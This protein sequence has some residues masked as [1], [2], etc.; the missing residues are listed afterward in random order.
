[1]RLV[2]YSILFS[3]SSIVLTSRTTDAQ[4]STR[5][6]ISFFNQTEA[7]L[8][9]YHNHTEYGLGTQ[10]S[11]K[12]GSGISLQTV[13]GILIHRHYAG[14]LGIGVLSSYPSTISL[15]IHFQYQFKIKDVIPFLFGDG[16]FC[17][18]RNNDA[19]SRDPGSMFALG[20]GVQGKSRI[21]F[22]MSISY[23]QFQQPYQTLCHFCGWQYLTDHAIATRIG[24]GF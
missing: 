24:F 9:V 21:H 3:F 14:G 12:G 6:R 23:I 19:Y 2:I 18:G 1:M 15:F 11:S 10:P 8:Y 5:K 20:A 4:D 16:G 22:V 13:N 7:G 17:P